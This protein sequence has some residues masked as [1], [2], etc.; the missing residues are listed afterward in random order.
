MEIVILL[1]NDISPELHGYYNDSDVSDRLFKRISRTGF[2]GLLKMLSKQRIK[3]TFWEK[4]LE[5][6]VYYKKMCLRDACMSGYI[7][8]WI[9]SA[10]KV[11]V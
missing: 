10:S 7:I 8:M 4:G 6:G 5:Y 11:R 3:R 9:Q 2:F 1:L